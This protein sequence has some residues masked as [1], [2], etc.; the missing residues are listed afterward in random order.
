MPALYELKPRIKI[1]VFFGFIK[2]KKNS[3]NEY[4]SSIQG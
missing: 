2:G 1:Q 4:S 3:W